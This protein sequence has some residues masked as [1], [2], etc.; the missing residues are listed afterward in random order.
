MPRRAERPPGRS[1][2]STSCGHHAREAAQDRRNSRSVRQGPGIRAIAMQ[3]RRHA[4]T[5]HVA[6]A[7]CRCGRRAATRALKGRSTLLPRPS[8]RGMAQ[9]V[10]ANSKDLID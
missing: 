5:G 8:G 6:G 9:N 4:R 1:A 3:R 7:S 2:G 10:R